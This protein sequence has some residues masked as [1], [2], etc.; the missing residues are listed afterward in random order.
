M[1]LVSSRRICGFCRLA[2][3]ETPF[4]T[5]SGWTTSY[6]VVL[7]VLTP[8]M[9]IGV[10]VPNSSRCIWWIMTPVRSECQ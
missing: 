4:E 3:F 9:L 10:W 1:W 7:A 6:A 5:P 8:D 2:S